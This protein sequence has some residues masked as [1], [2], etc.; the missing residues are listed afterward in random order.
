MLQRRISTAG[1]ESVDVGPIAPEVRDVVRNDVDG[2]S[3]AET[4]WRRST[5]HGGSVGW[6]QAG[7]GGTWALARLARSPN[8]RAGQAPRAQPWQPSPRPLNATTSS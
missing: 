4:A 3:S 1:I 7:A 8:G 6:F 5:P 2:G